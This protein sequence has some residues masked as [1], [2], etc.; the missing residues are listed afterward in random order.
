MTITIHD[1]ASD[2]YR[3]RAV[4]GTN[5]VALWNPTADSPGTVHAFAQMGMKLLRFPG[6]VPAQFYDWEKPLDSGWS[7]LTPERAG[8][9]AQ[10]G[11]AQ[12][13][14]QTNI[15]NDKT[16]HDK[17]TGKTF[18][19]NSSGEHQAG[20]V[21]FARENGITVAFWEIGNEPEMDAPQPI[22]ARARA[23]TAI[24][25]W[26]NAKYAE[27]VKAIRPVDPDARV[28]G[29]AATNTWF[30]WHEKNLEKFL[31]AHGNKQGTGPGRRDLPALV[32]RRRGD[33]GET[34]RRRTGLAA[35]AWTTSTASSPNTTRANSPSTSP[36]GTGPAADKDDSAMRNWPGHWATPT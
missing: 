23:R 13:V 1:A 4:R 7:L 18:R 25:D 36:S 31:V 11:G 14:F 9:M 17:K 2:P 33:L 8:T 5:L 3:L 30:W 15:A 22:K 20:W 28:M 35:G 12:M 26:Y 19:F 29:P 27:Q 21:S 16:E 24:Y 10:A 6:G 34:P 32:H